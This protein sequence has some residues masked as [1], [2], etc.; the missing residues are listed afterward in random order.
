[1]MF[2]E[3]V[4]HQMSLPAR[5]VLTQRSRRTTSLSAHSVSEPNPVY[6]KT[7]WWARQRMPE[8]ILTALTQPRT[9]I[10]EGKDRLG[11]REEEE[12]DGNFSE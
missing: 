2:S 10:V 9:R 5:A 3:N 11:S 8:K 6:S 1:M 4:K 12:D 7:E